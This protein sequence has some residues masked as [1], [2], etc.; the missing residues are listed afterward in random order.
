MTRALVRSVAAVVLVV[1][2][3]GCG[4]PS[5]TD[6][7]TGGGAGGGGGS[8]GGGV[9]GGGAGG[10]G[11]TEDAGAVDAGPGCR[12]HLTC[13]SGACQLDAGDCFNCQGD[14][15]CGEG[16]VCGTG[17]CHVPCTAQGD[18]PQG[19][20]CCGN[21]C[22]D[23]SRDPQHCGGCNQG[24]T[25]TTFCA[26]GSCAAANLSSVCRLPVATVML[27]GQPA[28]DGA[29]QQ[30]GAALLAACDGGLTTRTA[31]QRDAGVL[32]VRDGRPLQLGEL[33]VM[34]GGSFR[35]EAVRWFE[36]NNAAPVRDSSTA[37]Q[38]TLT[39]RDGGV[40]VSMPFS[41]LNAS[42]DLVL[43]QLA[44]APLGPVVLNASGFEGTGTAAAATY[45]VQTLL[46]TYP[47]LTDAWVVLE[48]GDANFNGTAEPTEFTVRGSGP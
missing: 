2:A 46:P 1:G 33:L 8:G 43:V 32:S 3:L 17:A 14:R 26:R 25:A 13:T 4:G 9:T 15:E 23:P 42:R 39:L 27:D 41:S 48:W 34:G 20:D 28:D 36:Q 38:A 30:L 40:V 24:C 29:S 7:G 47:T 21:R 44:R 45:F 10:G 31:G 22:V 37:T 11:G 16:K 19:W 12:A 5:G 6:G 35:Q 18:C